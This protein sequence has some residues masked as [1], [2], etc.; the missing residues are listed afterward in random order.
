MGTHSA[1]AVR[2]KP[3]DGI[4][5]RRLQ[6]L[7][8][9][10]SAKKRLLRE[11]RLHGKM[12]PFLRSISVTAVPNKAVKS[13]YDLTVECCA[14]I[15][16]QPDAEAVLKRVPP[17]RFNASRINSCRGAPSKAGAGQASFT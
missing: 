13:G 2:E 6:V 14:R 15:C 4:P 17:E 10:F 5:G 7:F 11:G 8:D 1:Y 16:L 9:S 3:K 12:S